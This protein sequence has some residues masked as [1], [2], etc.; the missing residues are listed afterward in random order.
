[1]T[2]RLSLVVLTAGLF[3]TAPSA[4]AATAPPAPAQARMRAVGIDPAGAQLTQ[5]LKQKLDAARASAAGK[6]V[7]LAT[8]ALAR[9][10]GSAPS[11]N[12]PAGLLKSRK[13]VP[14]GSGKL[15]AEYLTFGP[16]E[17]S[18]LLRVRAPRGYDPSDISFRFTE[19]AS[20]LDTS[21][22]LEGSGLI[23]CG[24]DENGDE[25]MK[26]NGNPTKPFAFGAKPRDVTLTLSA[27]GL[28]P[29][30]KTASM[31][32]GG[33]QV[34]ISIAIDAAPPYLPANAFGMQASN[35]HFG[36]A[37]TRSNDGNPWTTT[38]GEDTLGLGVN[39]GAG[40]VVTS[41]KI[42]AAQSQ[43]DPPGT[44]TPV[45][46]YRYAKIKTN[47]DAGRLQ[48]VVEWMYGPGESLSYTIEWTLTGPLGQRA[49]MTMPLSG[50][51][52]Q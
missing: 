14:S 46:A 11:R 49:L 45:N 27:Q 43:L 44:T 47:P 1:M 18:G 2:P 42:V 40:Y 32:G 23:C 12:L 50:P 24:Y 48:T 51:V 36:G 41:T 37:G 21:G 35:A 5:K 16:W 20:G 8:Q 30:V 29:L 3:A 28:T 34:K 39:L 26:I 9:A 31:M 10:G 33:Q 25:L 4:P 38:T 7:F 13:V 15:T 22:K 6:R 17:I 52:D 19:P